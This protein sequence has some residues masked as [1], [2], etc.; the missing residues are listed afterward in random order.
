M[1]DAADLLAAFESGELLRPGPEAPNLVD[2]ARGVAAAAGARGLDLSPFAQDLADSLADR[3][4]IVLILADGLG[5]EMLEAEERAPTLRAALRARLRTVF[6]SSTAVALT[7]LATGAWPARH[8]VTGWWTHFEEIGGPATILQYRRRSDNRSLL[9]LGVRPE[10][11]FPVPSLAGRIRRL[12]H[13]LMPRNIADS[14]YSRYWSGGP[15]AA[16]YPSLA[17]TFGSIMHTVMGAD[18]PTFVYVYV[19]HID[20][21]AH[22]AGPDSIGARAALIAID[23]LVS[24]L[25]AELG[26]AT[27]VVV[28]ADHGHLAVEPHDRLLIRDAD[29]IP[30]LLTS[31]PAGDS[32]V[33]EFRVRAGEHERFEERFR[34]SFGDRFL[35]LASAEVEELA[36]LGPDPLADETRERIGDYMAISRGDAVLGYHPSEASRR[37]LRQRSHHAGLTPAEMLIPLIV[38]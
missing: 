12:C 2:A 17:G 3:E 18:E 5:L 15:A 23:R 11:A 10:V 36:L 4:H 28:T 26:E 13:Y 22:Q 14:V 33:L 24:D 9:D 6:P 32:R 34:A 27:A 20:N 16:G 31:P 8:A 1:S 7:S 35:L 38:A 30:E 37:G 29:G 21:E 25:R 19:P